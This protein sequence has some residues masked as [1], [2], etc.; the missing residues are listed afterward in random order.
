MKEKK[1]LII[2]KRIF[3]NKKYKNKKNFKL[4][5]YDFKFIY[6]FLEKKKFDSIM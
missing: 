5:K 4:I 3:F 6:N 1:N 2:K